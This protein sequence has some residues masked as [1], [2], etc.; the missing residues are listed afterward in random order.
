MIE[1]HIVIKAPPKQ[2][3]ILIAALQVLAKNARIV[4]GCITVEVYQ[5]VTVPRS[6]CYDEIWDSESALHR[7]IDS[8]HFS[9]IAELMELST[10]PP[11][12]EFR[13]I[14]QT[15]GL[16]FAQKVRDAKGHSTTIIN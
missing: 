1:L 13:F 12:C 7:M 15:F 2:S 5:S 10:V 11:A 9:Q 3:R 4:A 14:S 16:D 8:H 6:I